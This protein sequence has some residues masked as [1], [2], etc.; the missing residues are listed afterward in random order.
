MYTVTGSATWIYAWI[1]RLLWWLR[2][3][4]VE[5][6][7]STRVWR[8]QVGGVLTLTVFCWMFVNGATLFWGLLPLTSWMLFGWT[9]CAIALTMLV[10]RIKKVTSELKDKLAIDPSGVRGE[11]AFAI[12]QFSIILVGN[13]AEL[14]LLARRGFPWHPEDNLNTIFVACGLTPLVAFALLRGIRRPWGWRMRMRPLLERF[15]WDAPWT[16]CWYIV[17]LKAIQQVV[18]LASALLGIT[19]PFFLFVTALVVLGS[20]RVR[21]TSRDYHANPGD[22]MAKAL[23]WG[24][25]IDLW[26]LIPLPLAVIFVTAFGPISLQG[27]L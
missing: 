26:T 7:G 18:Q 17:I 21:N 19:H 11:I 15:R 2:V 1:T 20:Y 3:V 22:T 12:A 25:K 5:L 16:R 4:R 13:F 10:R 9:S 14:V 8:Y 23:Y 24:S 6:R 27:L